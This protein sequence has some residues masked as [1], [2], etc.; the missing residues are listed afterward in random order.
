MPDNSQITPAVITCNGGLILNKDIFDMEPGEAL[1]LQ[2]FEPD[3]AGG[4]KKILGTTPYNSAI[5]PQVSSSN[6]I[7]DM[8]AIFNNVT[9]AARGGTVYRGGTSGSWTST[10][11]GKGTTYI[12]D[13]ERFNFNGTEKIIIASGTTNAFTIDTSFNE[14]II[15]ATGGGTAPTSPQFVTSFKNHIFYGGMSNANSTIQFS[16]PFAEDDFTAGNG[17]GA[18]KVDTT[19]VGLK[20]FRDNLFIFGEDRIYKLGGS[21][22]SDFS[23]VP[24]TRKIGC[25]D[26]KSIQEIGGDLIYLAP[27]GLRTIAGTER[28]GDVELGTVS[29]QIQERIKNI[30]TT[31]ISSTIIR[32]KSQYRLFYPTSGISEI[33]AK[34]I[35]AVLKQSPEGGLGFEYADMKGL[36]P[37]CCDSAFVSGVETVINGGFDGYVYLQESGGAFTRAGT[38]HIISSFYR[39]PDMTL[40]DGGIRKTM[41]RALVNYEVNES[42]DITNQ[43]FKLRYNFDDTN[44]P[45]PDSYTLSSSAASAAFY[46]SGLYGTSVY[47]ASGFPLDRQSVEGSGFVVAFKF[48]DT[49]TKKAISLKGFEL[50]FIPGGRR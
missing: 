22:L 10:A 42:V 25:V 39:S 32:G 29:K 35:I 26:G 3:I 34:G 49:S 5:V 9:L 47:S 37:T 27:D 17:A 12:Y 11:T 7:V 31:N 30:G 23:I 28:I 1:Q 20:V 43:F 16:A 33:N 48:E 38:T 41:Q 45:Q 18:I 14:D 46:G 40:G 6:E 19:I 21:T 50:E 13:F 15:N 24:V 8:V 44:T 2:N 4:Y 36:K